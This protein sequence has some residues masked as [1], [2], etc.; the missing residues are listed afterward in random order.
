MSKFVTKYIESVKGR[1]QFRQ[2]IVV[3]DDVDIDSLQ[4]EIIIIEDKNNQINK[5]LIQGEIIQIRDG[6][7]DIYE[8]SIEVKYSSSFKSILIYMN[9]VADIQTLPNT[10]FK[11]LK[12]AK[13]EIK[14]FEFKV[15]DLRVYGIDIYGGKLIL[16]CGY[17]NTQSQDIVKFR[18][19][20]SQY[21]ESI[22]TKTLRNE[23][24]RIN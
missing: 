22:N 4:H 23:K 3:A 1:Q 11:Y 9:L 12:T 17:K 14:E 24:R 10:K 6:V 18:S 16:Y 21:L 13:N 19:L 8:N 20:K 2:L 7:L 15:G 5:G